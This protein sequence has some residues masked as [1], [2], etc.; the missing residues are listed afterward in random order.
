MM[1]RHDQGKTLSIV[2][3][4]LICIIFAA[5]LMWILWWMISFEAP[6]HNGST[7]YLARIEKHIRSRFF[8][9]D[10]FYGSVLL[11]QSAPFIVV[12]VLSFAVIE[13]RKKCEV[14]AAAKKRIKKPGNTESA[15]MRTY[16]M[17]VRS[18]LG[19]LT[20]AEVLFI[21]AMLF[22]VSYTFART[23]SLRFKQ[24]DLRFK[25][26]PALFKASLRMTK[27]AS[28]SYCMGRA[29][30]IPFSLLWIPVSRGSPFL[31]LIKMPFEH[32]V[33]YH[34][35]LSTLTLFMLTLHAVGYITYYV[36]THTAHR[37]LSWETESETCSVLAGVVAWIVGLTMW[38]TSLSFFR[39]RWYELFFGVH[40]LYIVFFLFWL[41]HVIWT[42]HF[43]T[44]PCLLFMVDRFLRMLQ[45]RQSVDVLSARLLESGSLHLRIAARQDDSTQGLEYHALSSWYL[46]IP[47]LS[48]LLKLQWHFFS[49]TSTPMDGKE[50]LSIVIKP[51]GKWTANLRDQLSKASQVHD[52][53]AT[54]AQCPF[55]FKAGV[56]GPYGDESDFF[57]KYKV[58][59]LIG[60]GI[61][62]TPLL[63]LLGDV[64]HRQRL[65][66][67]DLPNSILLYYCVRKPEEL[68]VLSSVD[69]NSIVPEYEKN[70]LN[71]R[72]FAY[73]T[74]QSNEDNSW[75][76][77]SVQIESGSNIEE[78]LYSSK[79]H[80]NGPK[81]QGVCSISSKGE[82]IWVVSVII[83]SI[84]GFYVLWGLSNVFIVKHPE[85]TFPNYNRAHLVVTSM[86]L[87]ITV[88]G[89]MVVLAWWSHLKL[90]RKKL[91]YPTPL[92]SKSFISSEKHSSI[93]SM[94]TSSS[95]STQ[96]STS[97][98]YFTIADT[99]SPSPH[100]GLNI[101]TSAPSHMTG[102]PQE[103]TVTLDKVESNSGAT[104]L[105]AHDLPWNGSLQLGCRPRWND[106]F[107]GV[108]K[109]Y[110]G[111]NI[112]VLVSGPL[113]MREDI[114]NQ[115]K[116]H[117]SFFA[118]EP[119]SNVFHYHPISFDL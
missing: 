119:S 17:V 23:T 112:G 34:I 82:S 99:M 24:L 46:R 89:G 95:A 55:R 76:C 110:Q 58:L 94:S 40:H 87:G 43:F 19:V 13:L 5:S 68:C 88:F 45:S 65:G 3:H 91:N 53:V 84:L 118:R 50:E 97:Y 31:R 28:A 100:E 18:P 4:I 59:I 117:T 61:G 72:V 85:S 51:F 32:A 44:I 106:I 48:K 113:S 60:G 70:G 71:I 98:K 54:T 114:A 21:A 102:K 8:R 80:L 64:L 10:D 30:M 7:M 47:S 116:K 105:A 104:S 96:P 33:K 115:C 29:A 9:T 41:Y 108:N 79:I 92:S 103:T 107:I 69:P 38:T 36:A 101:N 77:S 27:L 57:L 22:L 2:K 86:V 37:I 20:A 56:E 74:T 109:E 15:R 111:Q 62:V 90:H 1:E 6:K 14:G 83:T 73:V 16:P 42:V 11:Y 49:V 67:G 66:Q 78:V 81:P 25:L 63:A 93:S 52:N 26:Q 12:A 39:R 35:W 75:K